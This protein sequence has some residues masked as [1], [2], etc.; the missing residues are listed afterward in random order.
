MVLR[1]LLFKL[2]DFGVFLG[3]RRHHALRLDLFLLQYPLHNL[4]PRSR[5]LGIL[6]RSLL[7]FLFFFVFL[8]LRSAIFVRALIFV[9]VLVI[10]SIIK[11]LIIELL[12]CAV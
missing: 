1:K 4:L 10:H 2:T 5:L 9:G 6:C 7:L 8:V 3:L 12:I 11:V